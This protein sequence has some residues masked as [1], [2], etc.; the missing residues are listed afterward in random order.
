MANPHK[1]EVGFEIDGTPYTLRFSANALCE[2]EDELGLGVNAIAGQLADPKDLR[3]KTVRAVFWAGLRDHHSEITL[4]QAGE[5]VTA[6]SLPV[7]LETI[8]NAFSAAF[9]SRETKTDPQKPVPSAGPAKTVDGTG[10]TS[11]ENGVNKVSTTKSSGP[12]RPGT[13]VTS[14][15]HGKSS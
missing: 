14:S 10:N 5:I 15:M 13:S 11:S 8:A 2:L 1:G 7:A 9:P 4:I 6:M 3:L 12:L